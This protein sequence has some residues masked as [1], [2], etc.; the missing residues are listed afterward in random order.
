MERPMKRSRAPRKPQ[1]D[2]LIPICTA[3]AEVLEITESP[4]TARFEI[5]RMIRRGDLPVTRMD[6]DGRLESVLPAAFEH[7]LILGEDGVV[8]PH[9][10]RASVEEAVETEDGRQLLRFAPEPEV[11]WLVPPEPVKWLC[12]VLAN[13]RLGRA[14]TVAPAVVEAEPEPTTV[15]KAK[16]APRKRRSKNT[17]TKCEA[18]ARRITPELLKRPW[19]EVLH[20]L[21]LHDSE[22]STLRRGIALAKALAKG[23]SRR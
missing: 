13:E 8:R 1:A 23:K 22:F 18:I 16:S 20:Q 2:G 6:A 12:K 21:G 9:T 15:A 19:K 10:F 17:G 4:S 14:R 11:L 3:F 5:L 7:D